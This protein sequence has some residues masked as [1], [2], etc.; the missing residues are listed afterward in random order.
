MRCELDPRTILNKMTAIR[1]RASALFSVES[2]GI[3][4]P[5]CWVFTA[6]SFGAHPMRQEGLVRDQLAP[7]A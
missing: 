7:A 5:G 1:K 6:G 3:G 2:T 4:L